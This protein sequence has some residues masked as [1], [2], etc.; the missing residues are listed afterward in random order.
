MA[1][2]ILKLHLTTRGYEL[3]AHGMLPVSAYLRYLEHQRWQTFTKEGELPVRRFWGVGVVRAQQL[4][5]LHPTSFHEDLELTLWVSR[6]GRTS[7]DF[8]HDIIR[9]SDGAV[10]A[11]STATVVAL[12]QQRQPKEIDPEAHAYVVERPGA[13]LERPT[14]QPPSTAWEQRVVIRPSDHDLQQHVNHARYADLIDDLRLLAASAGALGVPDG[15]GAL[16]SMY[17]QYDREAR[18]SDD[19]LGRIW[20][21]PGTER[22]LEA[23]LRKASGEVITRARVELAR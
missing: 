2:P 6:V 17:L 7:L 10:V 9:L 4:E 19:V 13:T 15:A 5:I 1:G 23:E 14:G 3:G 8:S 11:R 18:A 16:R 12:D 21:I 20:R 22:A